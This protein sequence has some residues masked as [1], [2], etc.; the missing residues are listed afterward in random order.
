[1]LRSRVESHNNVKFFSLEI[2]KLVE[3]FKLYVQLPS[4]L[5]FGLSRRLY[6]QELL[7]TSFGTFYLKKATKSGTATSFCSTYLIDLYL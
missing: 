6:C 3:M 7:V 5:L 2:L 1:M 4:V